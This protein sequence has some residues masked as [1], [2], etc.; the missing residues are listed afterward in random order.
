LKINWKEIK[1]KCLKSYNEFIRYYKSTNPDCN[2]ICFCDL[3]MFF[4]TKK[5]LISVTNCFE[6]TKIVSTWVVET[7][8][9]S[10]YETL[11]NENDCVVKSV[12]RAFE[13]LEMY[14]DKGEQTI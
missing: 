3:K 4:K 9:F 8:H 14:L 10:E 1:I 13:I 5:I 2:E 11:D 7:I 6:N 12:N